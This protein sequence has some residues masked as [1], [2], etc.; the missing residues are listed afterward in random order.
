MSSFR[1]ERETL[2]DRFTFLLGR[3]GG[4]LFFETR[5]VA[6]LSRVAGITLHQFEGWRAMH[7]TMLE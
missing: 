4:A 1:H 5:D 3:S 7:L 6:C 2:S